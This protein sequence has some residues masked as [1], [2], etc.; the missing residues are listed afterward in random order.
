ML[1]VLC[2]AFYLFL[3]PH[4]LCDGRKT[5][6]I[7]SESGWSDVI[8]EKSHLRKGPLMGGLYVD[9][10]SPIWGTDMEGE[11]DLPS[12]IDAIVDALIGNDTGKRQ[13]GDEIT[14]W[15]SDQSFG[16][17]K[18]EAP[19]HRA[20]QQESTP[21]RDQIDHSNYDEKEPR[22]LH[23]GRNF[24]PKDGP[25]RSK[26]LDRANKLTS[27]WNEEE[28]SENREKQKGGEEPLQNED[29]Y[30][31][32]EERDNESSEQG[33]KKKRTTNWNRN[34]N[35]KRTENK[36]TQ[37]GRLRQ[38][39]KVPTDTLT[40]RLNIR[41]YKNIHRIKKKTTKILKN[42]LHALMYDPDYKG[43]LV[44]LTTDAADLIMNQ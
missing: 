34:S 33:R 11:T 20:T 41:C 1:K 14:K 37:E 3:S 7:E 38:K 35:W 18:K 44:F 6:E 21:L 5:L 4:H 17:I 2:I 40:S 31:E 32:D 29:E 10:W 25:N 24:P 27:Q 16:D 42:M 12:D 13:H 36:R 8:V 22:V 9:E 30:N 15:D 39:K 23:Q 43:I 26:Y 19:F 28:L